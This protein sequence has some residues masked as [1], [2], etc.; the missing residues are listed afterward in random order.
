MTQI[1]FDK[2]I[3]FLNKV[4]IKFFFNKIKFNKAKC[5]DLEENSFLYRNLFKN[6]QNMNR[7]GNFLH[8]FL[9][10]VMSR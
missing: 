7:F 8:F 1:I 9:F 3:L 5:E 6:A 10:S 2:R 4:K